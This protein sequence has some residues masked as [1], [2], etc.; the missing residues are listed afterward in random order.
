MSPRRLS[1]SACDAQCTRR[2]HAQRV[3]R[4]AARAR[5]STLQAHHRAPPVAGR[6]RARDRAQTTPFPEPT[7]RSPRPCLPA[8][9]G[10]P[11]SR[12][13][14]KLGGCLLCLLRR[15][16]R[17]RVA[18][19]YWGRSS[20]RHHAVRSREPLAQQGSASAVRHRRT[21]PALRGPS[22]A[23][24]FLWFALHGQGHR[25][26]RPEAHPLALR[27]VPRAQKWSSRR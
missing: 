9:R 25:E 24:F 20:A 10:Q 3:S 2:G 6:G 4:R 22:D 26:P 13:G 15:C 8:G 17:P 23:V 14:I 12:S 19:R 11:R 18:E 1:L 21:S 27:A 5:A 16:R 7:A